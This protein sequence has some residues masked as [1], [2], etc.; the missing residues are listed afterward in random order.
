[1]G[2]GHEQIRQTIDKLRREI[3]QHNYR[4]YV[5]DAPTIT[6]AQY[7]RL[8]A[9]LQRLEKE[10]PHLVTPDSPT[11][12]VGGKPREG[13]ATVQH[14]VAMLSLANAFGETELVDFDRRVRGVLGDEPYD[15]VVELKIDGLAVSL[16]YQDSLL[17]RGA[18]R[19]D[20]TTGEDITANLKTIR[21]IPLRLH[22]PVHLLEVRGEVYMPKDSFVEL[23]S[24]RQERGEALFANPRNAAAG[25]L[26]QL[27]PAITA[28]RN[29]NIFVY[30]IGIVDISG[31]QPPGSHS[32]ALKWLESLG[33]R[34][35]PHHQLCRD[36]NEVISYC[37]IWQ[38]RKADLPYQ[39]D[40]LVIKVNTLSQQSALG[41][42]MKS[43]RWAIAFKFPPEQAKTT[44]RDIIVSVGRTGVITPTALLDPV[45]VAGST[46]SRATLHN[47]DII[48]EKDIRIGD[49]VI[50]QKA[51]DVIPEVVEVLKE[52]RTGGEK[53]F[54]MPT[55][56]PAC[57]AEVVRPAGEAAH[58]CTGATCPAQLLEGL[59]HFASRGAMDI[60]GLGPA[61]V[62]QLV[63]AGL[64]KDF[65]DLYGLTVEQLLKLERFGDKSADNLVRAI[66]A[67]KENPLH[68]LIFALGIRH[69]GERAARVLA[70][71]FGDLRKLMDA[72]YEELISIV[73][74][75]PKIAE[76]VVNFMREPRNR[77][78]IERLMD[79]GVNVVAENPAAGVGEP[80]KGKTFV[81]TGTLANLKRDDAKALIEKAGGKVSSSVSKKTDYV[82]AGENPGS[83]YEKA[84][85]LG[86]PV[87]GEQD[88]LALFNH[89]HGEKND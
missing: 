51:G 74:I 60:A 18:T 45:P 27:D 24:R 81:L 36:I 29:L 9:E 63:E 86:V 54:M 4:Y 14:P 13:F 77:A 40:G 73:E 85:K 71:H 19:G 10:Y 82:V 22:K 34:V 1:M 87:L 28:G 39:I 55:A 52:H 31:D 89:G 78:L 80:L 25:S 26:R 59:I 75:G 83:K 61:V 70:G 35:N 43:P 5:L 41:A 42:T 50:I 58:R 56:C 48:R 33:L 62:T 17:V 46:V 23:N 21:S 16:T 53:P 79:Q 32:E 20:G 6:D 30:G 57:G 3:E 84:I 76:S 69:V 2:G 15:Y 47:E 68:R 72:S 44:V 7:D 49:R 38:D 64:V 8:M 11:Q 88:F 65:S 67:S 37:R 12:R 66:A